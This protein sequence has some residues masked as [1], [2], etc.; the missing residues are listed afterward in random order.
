MATSASPHPFELKYLKG[1]IAV[2]EKNNW[3]NLVSLLPKRQYMHFRVAVDDRDAWVSRV[4]EAG[5]P[6]NKLR[7]DIVQ[8]TVTP[9][10]FAKNRTLISEIIAKSTRTYQYVG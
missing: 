3:R 5:L 1:H 7:Q 8:V 10:Q 6:I 4:E 9:D 2:S